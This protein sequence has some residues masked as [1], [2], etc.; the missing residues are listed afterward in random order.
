MMERIRLYLSSEHPCGY[1]PMRTARSLFVDPDFVLNP[2]RYESLLEQGYRR[3]GDHVYRP[4]CAGCVSCIPARIPVQ[5]FRPNR[6]QRRCLEQNADLRIN[7]RRELTDEQFDL[8]QRYLRERHAGGGMNPE[9]KTGFHS[10]LSCGW[11]YTEFWEF[12]TQSRALMA[13]AVVDRTPHA[14][15]AVYTFYDPSVPQRGLGSYAVLSQV[16]GAGEEGLRHVYLGYWVPDR[17]KMD[18]KR[19]F[20]PLEVLTHLGWRTLD[21]PQQKPEDA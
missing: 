2:S 13:C 1:L 16:R 6:S 7:I 19:K 11:G 18:Y 14:L 21:E 8:Y 17:R 12:R 15:S 4:R 20:K 5:A 9:D 3:G 10:F